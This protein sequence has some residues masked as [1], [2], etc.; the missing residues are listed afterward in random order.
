MERLDPRQYRTRRNLEIDEI[1]P[2]FL[3]KPRFRTGD[4]EGIADVSRRAFLR[5]PVARRG[6][7]QTRPP[8]NPI[9]AVA[10]V[11]QTRGA[12]RLGVRGRQIR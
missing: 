4:P 6:P 8:P 7:Q 11:R 10:S 2:I 12:S 3:E 5:A 1:A 9:A